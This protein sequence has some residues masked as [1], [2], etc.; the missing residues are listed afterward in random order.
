MDSN[1]LY[2]EKEYAHEYPHCW[3]TDHPLLYYAMDSWFVR[4]TAVKE[5]LLE[6][7]N[8]VEWA[9]DHPDSGW[10]NNVPH[11]SETHIRILADG[12]EQSASRK[13]PYWYRGKILDIELDGQSY[14]LG[15]ASGDGCNCLIDTLRQAI[16]GIICSVSTVRAA[17]ENRHRGLPSAIA[18][19]DFLPLELWE[20]VIDLLGIHNAL[21]RLQTS[22][23]HRFRVVCVDLTWIG[24]GDV[25]PRGAA[26]DS[27]T[28]LPIARVNQNH[29]VPLLRLHSCDA[30]WR[31]PEP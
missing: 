21:G 18:P 31:R 11:V 13:M 9:P 29:F 20:D 3:R 7:N 26:S 23:A 16:P 1:L 19:G 30:R 10:G 8:Q 6:F 12:V 25:F 14:Y 2:R 28:T 17:L 5:R 15:S 22:W 24:N 27:R 4:M